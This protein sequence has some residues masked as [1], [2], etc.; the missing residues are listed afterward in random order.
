MAR[1]TVRQILR[2]TKNDGMGPE[3]LRDMGTMHAIGTGF[4]VLSSAIGFFVLWALG[5]API[6]WI[7]YSAVCIVSILR[8]AIVAI[9]CFREVAPDEE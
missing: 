7:V 2:R 8:L 9:R 6:V 3:E 1:E 5:P 4:A